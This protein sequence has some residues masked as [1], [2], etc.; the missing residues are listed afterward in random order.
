M[1]EDKSAH[2]STRKVPEVPAVSENMSFHADKKEHPSKQ[3]IPH[4]GG[5]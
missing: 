5:R 2:P 3:K 1:S 4:T